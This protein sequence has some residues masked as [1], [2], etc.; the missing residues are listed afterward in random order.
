MKLLPL[1][2]Y[3][4]IKRNKITINLN[5]KIIPKMNEHRN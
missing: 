3:I 5:S 4:Y 2:E 1:D